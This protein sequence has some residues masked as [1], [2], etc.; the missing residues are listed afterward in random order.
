VV[1]VVSEERGAIS[2]CSNGRMVPNLDE[3]RLSRQLHRLFNLDYQDPLEAP[4]PVSER[5][6]S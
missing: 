2:L 5:R 4:A 1:I 6:V 3:H